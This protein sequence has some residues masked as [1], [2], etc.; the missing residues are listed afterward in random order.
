MGTRHHAS[1]FESA[2]RKGDLT[3]NDNVDDIFPRMDILSKAMKE[4]LRSRF[5]ECIRTRA[6]KSGTWSLSR[7]CWVSWAK[8][9]GFAHLA[10]A[11][12][13]VLSRFSFCRAERSYLL[14]STILSSAL[15]K[16]E[17]HVLPLL[18]T[19]GT[20]KYRR[21]HACSVWHRLH[22]QQLPFARLGHAANV[23]RSAMPHRQNTYIIH[24]ERESPSWKS[25]AKITAQQIECAPICAP[26]TVQ[27]TKT[28]TDCSVT[29]A[30]SYMT[31]T[32]H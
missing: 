22:L 8:Q 20:G 11:C 4:K 1:V 26:G 30:G 25:I 24:V 12:S 7:E 29:R 27:G 6:M 5:L 9:T 32:S 14:C 23:S 18:Q 13:C 10:D 31:T 19:P 2:T 21:L 28:I 16:I 17:L 15:S 3:F